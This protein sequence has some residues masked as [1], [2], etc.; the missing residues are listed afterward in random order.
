MARLWLRKTR[1]Y[2]II[3][4][5]DFNTDPEKRTDVSS[6]INDFLI[7]H[8]LIIYVMLNFYL[9]G[10]IPTSMS[11]WAIVVLLTIFFV[12]RMTFCWTTV[13][14]IL[15]WIFPITCLL[16]YAVSAR[17]SLL[18]QPLIYCSGQRSSSCAGTM[19]TCRL[20]TTLLCTCCTLCSMSWLSWLSMQK[21]V[22]LRFGPRF[23]NARASVTVCGRPVIWVTSARYLGVY[24][25][26]SFTFNCSLDVNKTKFYKAFNCTFGKIESIASE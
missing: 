17:V 21:S 16:R 13:Y 20:I 25:E 8:S 14:W 15:V 11:R 3:I 2:L 22:C 18:G 26:S 6:Y 24:L 9:G 4:G 19:L 10:S 23:R 5:G 12:M 7:N 1:L